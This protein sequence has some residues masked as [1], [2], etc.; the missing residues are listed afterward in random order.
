VNR[1]NNAAGVVHYRKPRIVDMDSL[2]T[3]SGSRHWYEIQ[4]EKSLEY[5][6]FCPLL[7]EVNCHRPPL[8]TY[9]SGDTRVEEYLLKLLPGGKS[10]FLGDD[11][12]GADSIDGRSGTR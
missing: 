7:H 11:F 12:P 8:L 4:F 9:P 10:E 2:S 6:D 5:F 3:M 1:W